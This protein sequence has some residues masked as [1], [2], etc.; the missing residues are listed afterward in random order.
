MNVNQK[1]QSAL[2]NIDRL[3]Q[4][5]RVAPVSASRKPRPGVKTNRGMSSASVVTSSAK[6]TKI[7]AML[8]VGSKPNLRLLNKLVNRGQITAEEV[9]AA[10]S[11]ALILRHVNKRI[12]EAIGNALRDVLGVED[13]ID[14]EQA[15]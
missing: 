3:L 9:V 4:A 8:G 11:E 15:A 5:K 2:S 10:V 7:L 13:V 12:V 1:I 6:K 14:I